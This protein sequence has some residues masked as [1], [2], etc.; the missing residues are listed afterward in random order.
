MRTTHHSPITTHQSPKDRRAI[1]ILLILLLFSL[2]LTNQSPATESEELARIL[3]QGYAPGELILKLDESRRGKAAPFAGSLERLHQTFG[4]TAQHELFPTKT[5]VGKAGKIVPESALQGIYQLRLDPDADIEQAASAYQADPSVLYAQPNYLMRDCGM[6]THREAAKSAKNLNSWGVPHSPLTTHQSPITNDPRYADQWALPKLGWD[7]IFEHAKT[8]Q[9]V[10][11]AIVD[12]GVDYDHEDLSERIWINQAERDGIEGVDDD[13]NGYVDDIRGWDFTDAPTLPGIGD[14]TVRDNDPMDESGHGTH[15]AGIVGAASDNGKGIAGIAPNARLMCLR[16]G[17][18]LSIGGFLEDDD[19]ASAIVYAADNGAQGINM[20]WGDPRLCPLI[21][22]VIRYAAHQGCVL[23][24][25]AGNEGKEALYYPAGLDETIAVSAIESGDNLASYANYGWNLDVVAPGSNI[26]STKPD[27]H[28]GN[29]GGTSMA[30][31][32]VSALAALILG[33]NPDYSPDEVKNL[34]LHTA[35][36]LGTPGWDPTFGAGRIDLPQALSANLGPTVQILHP[37]SGDGGDSALTI[38]GTAAGGDIARWELSTGPG[39]HPETWT[40]IASA[41]TQV[42]RDTLTLWD[43]SDLADSKY[44]LRLQAFGYNGEKTEDRVIVTV[45]H[46]PP[47]IEHVWIAE[48]MDGVR[49]ACFIEWATDDA[50]TG[51]VHLRPSGSDQAT[52]SLDANVFSATHSVEISQSLSPGTYDFFITARNKA[53]LTVESADSTCAIRSDVIPEQGYVQVAEL[54]NG[55]LTPQ[56]ADFDGDGQK[57]IILMPYGD[58]PYQPVEFY[59]CTGDNAF[60]HVFTL[61]E[62]C[63]PWNVCDADQDGKWELMGVQAA[64]LLLFESLDSNSFPSAPIWRGDAV[65]GGAAFDLDRDGRIALIARSDRGK[66]LSVFENDGDDRFPKIKPLLLNPTTGD[67][68]IGTRFAIGDYD[69]DGRIE[70]VFG[71]SDGDLFAYEAQANDIYT[72]TILYEQNKDNEVAPSHGLCN[73]VDARHIAG[74][75]DLD[76]DGNLEFVVGRTVGD[77]I[78]PRS[79]RWVVSVYQARGNDT[80][81]I[82]WQTE[83]LGVTSKGNGIAIGDVDGDGT[84]EFVV[85]TRPD[86]Y[87]FKSDGENSYR[88]IYHVETGQTYVPLLCDADSDGLPE[89][90]FNQDERVVIY[91]MEPPTSGPPAP[92]G[93]T[94]VPMDASSVQLTWNTD[95]DDARTYRLYRGTDPDALERIAEGTLS[96]PYTDRSLR[97]D[98]PYFYALCVV[99]TNLVPSESARFPIVRATPN[100]PPRLLEAHP[101]TPRHVALLFNEPLG[102]SAQITTH[103]TITADTSGICNPVHPASIIIDQNNQRVLLGFEQV[104]PPGTYTARVEGVRDTTGVFLSSEANSATFTM[105]TATTETR[106][107]SAQVLSATEIRLVFSEG[108]HD[109][110]MEISSFSILPEVTIEAIVHTSAGREVRLL[111]SESDPLKAHGHRYEIHATDLTDLNGASVSDV[112]YLKWARDDLSHLLVFPNPCDLS[113]SALTFANLTSEPTIQ[114]YTLDGV[115]LKTMIEQDGDGGTEWDGRNEQGERIGSGIYLYS[116]EGKDQRRMGKF[117]VIR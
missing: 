96:T 65:W 116:V 94:A 22:D 20:S 107:L 37:Q 90:I 10:L 109:E 62:A 11:V 9:E 74:G 29:L 85:C 86:I 35:V 24:A 4:V 43:T 55:Y 38:V 84:D 51:R 114:V 15:V 53:G 2:L 45:D 61:S 110:G 48:R 76:G 17:L 92:T 83:I 12:S 72:S 88:P 33:E 56:C 47:E 8:F 50:T 44:V 99:D 13:G 58:S 78:D 95:A 7:R 41:T 82:E 59:E 6:K 111:L 98:V 18:R 105:E 25:A 23:V 31:P 1:S 70:I 104:L 36:D 91:E 103:Y 52:Q 40:L 112:A 49:W 71:D 66:A 97:T 115:L 3:K 42:Y 81:E 64:R 67:N 89:I 46:T 30:T 34:I 106:I 39:V 16:A 113:E 57:E 14:Y 68:D 108:I 60:E 80:Y 21:R 54:P 101:L 77:S 102:P 79:E 117:A 87:L 5:P 26:L 93:L 100:F 28:Y 73:E 69:G 75:S 32:H 27:D 63:L 19:V